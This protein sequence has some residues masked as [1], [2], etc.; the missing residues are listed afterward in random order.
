MF[1]R[2]RQIAQV[3]NTTGLRG[4]GGR[5][6]PGSIFSPH[7]S[8]HRWQVLHAEAKQRNLFWCQQLNCCSSLLS[9]QSTGFYL[10]LCDCVYV[11]V[12]GGGTHYAYMHIL[13]FFLRSESVYAFVFY[14]YG[15]TQ[16]RNGLMYRSLCWVKDWL[17]V[18]GK[19]FDELLG[20]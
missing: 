3:I 11:C 13:S 6:L 14:K 20:R 18:Q 1:A 7:I 2:Q 10:L 8:L 5:F 12:W 15:V 19:K 4:A 17:R 16:S 9:P